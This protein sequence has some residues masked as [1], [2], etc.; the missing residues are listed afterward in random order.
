MGGIM[1][2]WFGIGNKDTSV[3]APSAPSTTTSI[4]DWAANL[5]A[6]YEAQQ[7]YAPLEAAQQVELAQKYATP[8]SQA[9]YE[10]QKAMYPQAV[11]L[12]EQL[13]TRALAG[14]D[15]GLSDW[16]QQ[17]Y[18]S[19]L[20]AQLGN[21]VGSGIGA[22]YMSRGMLAQQQQRQD[23]YRNLGLSVAGL[24]PV[25]QAQ[26]AQSTNYMSN[27]TPTST[28]SSNNANYG[29]SAGI[30]N[31]TYSANMQNAMQQSQMANKYLTSGIGTMGSMFL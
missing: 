3:A 28:M 11:G 18:R 25:Q 2:D 19:D 22:D 31:N 5:P 20:G 8:L 24:Q 14:M 7:K 16:E 23:Y 15:A 29:T 10:A 12:Q 4:A 13:A 6:I 30:Y 1:D 26:G 17:Q 27:F 21:N 9:Y